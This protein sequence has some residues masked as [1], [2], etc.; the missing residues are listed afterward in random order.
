[1]DCC[2]EEFM[3]DIL[4]NIRECFKTLNVETPEVTGSPEEISTE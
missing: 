1:M 2:D 3:K 4:C